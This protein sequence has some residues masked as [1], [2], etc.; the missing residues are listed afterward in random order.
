MVTERATQRG[1]VVD[2]A[3]A[4]R[5]YLKKGV[6]NPD[7]F[8]EIPEAS[9]AEIYDG[10]ANNRLIEALKNGERTHV[11]GRFDAH[12]LRRTAVIAAEVSIGALLAV[13]AGYG[14]VRGVRAIQKRRL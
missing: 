3:Q 8:G 1:V 9:L 2:F 6:F 4:L 10:S 5:R 11:G 12:H 13:A 7:N 14:V